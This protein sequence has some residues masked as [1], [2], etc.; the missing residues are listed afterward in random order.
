[1]IW[2]YIELKLI[3]WQKGLESRPFYYGLGF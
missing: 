1:M 3:K 2:D